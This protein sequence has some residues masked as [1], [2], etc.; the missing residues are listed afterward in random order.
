[1]AKKGEHP[2]RFRVLLREAGLYVRDVHRETTIP[3]S[4][5]HYWAAGRGVI[6][7]EDR[8]TL[9]RLI[10][11]I[12]H[13]LAPK[14]DMLELRYD[15]ASSEW[16]REMLIKRRELLQLL[17]IAGG[18]LLTTNIDW[19]R[20]GTSLT[21]P[22]EI[23]D[24]VV[25][26]LEAINSRCWS[27]FMAASPKSSILDAV[28]GQLKMQIQFL[29]E[30]HT[31]RTHQRLCA[32]ISNMSQLAGEIFFDLHDH[33]TAQSCYVFAASSAKE[34]K[35]FDLWASALVRYSYLPIFEE[36]YES[37]VPLL[38]QAEVLAQRGDPAL[39]TRYWVA[40]TY[41]EAEAG[42]GNIKACQSTFERAHGVGTLTVICPAWIRFDESR[43]PAL[44]GAS[45]IRLKRPD[46]A[47][48][49]LQQALQQSA[50]TSRRRAMI[51]SDLALS[52]L[53]QA[54]VEKAC[55]YAEEVVTLTAQSA[56]GF[57]RNNI[58]KIQQ[59]LTPFASVEAVKTLEQRMA[60]LV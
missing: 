46:L 51:L 8:I 26:D 10:G 9:A 37:A 43:L 4:T 49:I 29:K 24:A 39:P 33:D 31:T 12:P 27:L 6:P 23:D 18:A 32:L 28:L 36:R 13:D 58:L 25:S 48:P 38:E 5:L 14:Y 30:V 47:E 54:D 20:I 19:N 16:G 52:A 17:S 1:M 7:Q 59:Q 11:C 53:Q 2:N 15:N 44:Q 3:E 42:I 55:A 41:A 22:S 35:A 45:Y 50:K 57:L 40:A 21:S 34:A 60:T 56:S